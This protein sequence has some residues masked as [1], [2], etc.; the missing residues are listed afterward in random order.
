MVFPAVRRRASG[1][2]DLRS[3]RGS[4]CSPMPG[5]GDS[6]GPTPASPS[7]GRDHANAHVLVTGHVFFKPHLALFAIC[8]F[9]TV[10]ADVADRATTPLTLA[11]GAGGTVNTTGLQTEQA[12]SAGVRERT[13]IAVLAAIFGSCIGHTNEGLRLLKRQ[14]KFRRGRTVDPGCLGRPRLRSG[15]GT[16]SCLY[17]ATRKTPPVGG[18]FRRLRGG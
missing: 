5:R 6:H 4:R 10:L 7:F 15:A 11:V 2:I 3:E 14:A 13:L 9:R 17:G 8:T 1:P 12:R 18:V 16:A